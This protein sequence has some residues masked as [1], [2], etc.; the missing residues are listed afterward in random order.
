ML[1][2][3][4]Y[5][6]ACRAAKMIEERFDMKIPDGEKGFIAIHIYTARV[7]CEVSRTVK[8]ASMINTMIEIIEN[9]L[10][11][12]KYKGSFSY[13]RKFHQL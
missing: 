1:C 13:I 9:E 8:Y 6:L 4:D 11:I 12:K 5:E 3:K 7:N 10:G 2:S